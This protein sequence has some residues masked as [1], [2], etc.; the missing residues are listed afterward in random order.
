MSIIILCRMKFPAIAILFFS[1][2]A[3]CT[4]SFPGIKVRA[5]SPA[6]AEAFRKL[7]L[8]INVDGY[9]IESINHETYSFETQWR[10]LKDNERVKNENG[11]VKLKIQLDPRGRLYDVRVTPLVQNTAGDIHPLADV[12]HPLFTKWKRIV[13]SIVEKE[14]KDED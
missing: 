6:I 12:Q 11:K 9:E 13:H 5:A 10:E 2:L 7:S 1:L 3:G 14:S 4:S 8:A